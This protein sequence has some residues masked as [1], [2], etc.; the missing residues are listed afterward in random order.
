MGLTRSQIR[1]RQRKHTRRCLLQ[2]LAF[3]RFKKQDGKSSYPVGVV[4]AD[5]ES[6]RE[7]IYASVDIVEAGG[8]YGAGY[9]YWPAC[10]TDCHTDFGYTDTGA[11]SWTGRGNYTTGQ[12]VDRTVSIQ[13]SSSLL[14]QKNIYTDALS[15]P[16]INGNNTPQL[17]YPF[18]NGNNTSEDKPGEESKDWT[19]VEVDWEGFVFTLGSDDIEEERVQQG[20]DTAGPYRAQRLDRLVLQ[21]LDSNENAVLCGDTA[22]EFSDTSFV[23]D[24]RFV[25]QSDGDSC[26]S[27][28]SGETDNEGAV[29]GESSSCT[30]EAAVEG[31]SS[32]G[33]EHKEL[34]APPALHHSGLCRCFACFLDNRA[35]FDNVH[36]KT[37]K[38]AGASNSVKHKVALYEAAL[39]K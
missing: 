28:S 35:I 31:E 6:F 12:V 3:F 22:S 17:T 26:S 18:I 29:E 19:G 16:F 15:Y 10:G 30:E 20:D 36:P 7:D 33:I 8:A 25:Y 11:S 1:N 5:L 37:E 38:C 21:Y 4:A 24:G 32:S 23:P 34:F 39:T 2:S 9:F 14:G 27:S 13:T